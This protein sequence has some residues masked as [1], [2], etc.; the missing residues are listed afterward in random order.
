MSYHAAINFVDIQ[1][2]SIGIQ[3]RQLCVLIFVWVGRLG[4][5]GMTLTQKDFLL[6][7]FHVCQTDSLRAVT[8]DCNFKVKP[9][10]CVFKTKEINLCFG[11]L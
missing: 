3:I 6:L 7:V 5:D 10:N 11:Q 4:W 2:C 8:D 9:T 1:T